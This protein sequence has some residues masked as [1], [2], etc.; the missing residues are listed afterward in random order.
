ML[1]SLDIF[2]GK[3]LSRADAVKLVKLNPNP[4]EQDRNKLRA[5]W[6]AELAETR[7]FQLD[8]KIGT[9]PWQQDI[10]SSEYDPLIPPVLNESNLSQDRSMQTVTCINTMLSDVNEATFK[11]VASYA[12]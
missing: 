9:H 2:T 10:Y 5:K 4:N 8:R 3:D 7:S 1:V 11:T 12:N 6:K